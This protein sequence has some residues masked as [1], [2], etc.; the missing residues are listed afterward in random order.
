MRVLSQYSKISG[1]SLGREAKFIMLKINFTL[2]GLPEEN[3]FIII[4]I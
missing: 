3:R 4:W 2:N 1:I